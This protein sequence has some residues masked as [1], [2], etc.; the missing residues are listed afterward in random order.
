MRAFPR[1]ALQI[2]TLLCIAW[3]LVVQVTGGVV[4]PVEGVD[5]T[6]R[7]PR[8]AW[9][10]ALVAALVAWGL[11][12]PAPLREWRRDARWWRLR[13]ATALGAIRR[14]WAWL[15]A[16]ALVA[17]AAGA[18]AFEWALG[19]P[20]WLDEQM[21]AI[22]LRERSM[23][24]LAGALWLGQ[25]APY[26]WLVL[27][28]AA[29]VL[30]GDGE[31]ALRLVPALFAAAT[32]VAAFVIGRRWLTP[33]GATMLVLCVVCGEWV[34]FYA[35]ELKHYSADVLFGLTLPA[36][37]AW[38]SEAGTLRD[39]HRRLVTWWI[40]AAAGLWVANGALLVAPGCAAALALLTWR[41]HGWHALW[42][43]AALGLMWLA[44]FALHYVVSVRYTLDNAYLDG[45]WAFALPPASA[46]AVETLR[47]FA[48]TLEPLAIKP[49]GSGWGVLFWVAVAAGLIA[50]M[51]G[52]RARLGVIVATVPASAF[53]FAAVRQVPLFERLSLWMVP[54]L[55]VG[56]ALLADRASRW[57][58]AGRRRP[59]PLRVIA[60]AA[61]AVAVLLLG[62][63]LVQ[64]GY[65]EFIRTSESN[66]AL[67]DRRA[68][69]W[70]L[71]QQQPGDVL[72]TTRLALPAV[73]W[74]GGVPLTGPGGGGALPDG[75]P[76]LEVGY[77]RPGP[78]CREDALAGALAG[79]RR[80]IVY[81]GFR[82]D[83]VPDGF[84]GLLLEELSKLGLV[85]A[86]E[87]FT[88]AGRAAVFDLG[89][90]TDGDWE[91]PPG[92]EGPDGDAPPLDGCLDVRVASAW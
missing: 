42:R 26:G 67:D 81:F 60:S 79:R 1:R 57:R 88:D 73:W 8:N 31:P 30:F 40:V 4:V 25:S 15:P 3:A 89:V 59:S 61:A 53:L 76:I 84:D 50:T 46:G 12:W 69:Q 45:Y 86:V 55:Y 56:L 71:Q 49:G 36:L 65:G 48:G 18:L 51:G 83:D 22:N 7:S 78:R 37:A 2:V 91:I 72:L 14:H 70:M 90:V 5:I 85:R 47:W 23:T 77:R 38:A 29:F 92:F 58:D 52:P 62:V 68:V 11:A 66:H 44:S 20:L 64:R 82:F 35:L 43:H 75:S 74:Y 27:Q 87:S 28:R 39:L 16:G 33:V 6:S 54:A 13:A 41:H 17:G 80:A 32:P 10:I 9:V 24:D 19:R 63:D 34:L 21:I